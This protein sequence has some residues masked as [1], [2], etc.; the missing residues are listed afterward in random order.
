MSSNKKASVITLKNDNIVSKT[1]KWNLNT[2]KSNLDVVRIDEYFQSP[3]R[4][5]E[6]QMRSYYD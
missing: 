6:A 2:V 1:V 5:T 4:W 3:A